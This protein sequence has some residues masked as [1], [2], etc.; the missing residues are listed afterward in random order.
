MDAFAV[1]ITS[2]FTAKQLRLPYALKI[3]FF[4][5][6]FQ[7]IMP[8]IG[9][10]LGYGIR[11]YLSE[12]DHWIAFIILSFIGG[13]MI[14]EAKIIKKEEKDI[15]ILTTYALLILSIATSIDALAVGLSLSAI[16]ISILTPALIIGIVTFIF[17]IIGVFIGNRFGH[18][19]E[20]E[21][22]TIGG[23]I[24]IGIGIKI[25]IEHI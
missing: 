4:F 23:L 11:D 22:E 2:G 5:G 1:S 12:I 24:L 15:L 10:S 14:Y 25:L 18:L 19:F 6:L 3:A 21:I 16:N 7:A 9:W 8:L 17:C 13:K 20:S